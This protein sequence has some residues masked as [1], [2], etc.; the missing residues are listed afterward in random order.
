MER[1]REGG[2]D[3]QILGVALCLVLWHDIYFTPNI[4]VITI[5]SAVNLCKICSKQ[6]S[7]PLMVPRCLPKGVKIQLNN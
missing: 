2:S 6:Y 4:Y 7:L 5:I 1:Q 3:F